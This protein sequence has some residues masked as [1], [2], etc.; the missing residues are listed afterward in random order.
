MW[1]SLLT[2][3][4]PQNHGVPSKGTTIR[5]QVQDL[6]NVMS[7]SKLCFYVEAFADVNKLS[8]Y[9]HC[10]QTLNNAVWRQP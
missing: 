4:Q 8:P 2:S 5:K 6:V 3:L 7:D 9:G 10:P 1:R